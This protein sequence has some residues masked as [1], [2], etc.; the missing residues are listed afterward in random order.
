MNTFTTTQVTTQF[1]AEVT[2]PIAV[3]LNVPAG[4]V[5]LIAADRTD[6]TVQV[7]PADP[8]KGRDVKAAEQTTVEFTDGTLHV[9]AP[10]GGGLTGSGSV[11]VTVQL[12]A[13]SRVRGEAAATE[14]RGVGRLGEVVFEGAYRHIKLDEAAGM[15][16][17]A[18]DGDVQV[19]RLT[20]PAAI[21]TQRGAIR[22]G[23]ATGG[24]VE[25]STRS[26]DIT[27]GAAAGVPAVLDAGTAHGRITN[28]LAND[29][30]PRLLVRATTS[31]GDI[32]ARS[33]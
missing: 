13:G 29:G 1:T 31:Q 16:L 2:A 11:E 5:Q 14:L 32:T 3:V 18:A 17:T 20:G 19:G 28:T 4:R 12:P 6:A 24:Q 10:A 26:G 30:N 25:L 8:G 22:I 33:L 21:S 27:I 9:H 7:R 23:E 15:R